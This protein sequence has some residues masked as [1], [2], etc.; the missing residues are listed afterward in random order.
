MLLRKVL[1]LIMAHLNS[2]PFLVWARL[3]TCL[4][5]VPNLLD[6]FQRTLPGGH[7]PLTLKSYLLSATRNSPANN[8]AECC[9]TIHILLA[10]V[11]SD[12]F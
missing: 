11:R 12:Y 2:I 5:L 1:C 9:D 6:P 7:I 8:P 10:I 4:L 3:I